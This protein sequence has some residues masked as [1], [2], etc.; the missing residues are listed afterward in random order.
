MSLC[1]RRTRQVRRPRCS[2]WAPT[3]SRCIH[4]VALNIHTVALDIH[5]VALDIHTV[6]LD[7][8]TV[9]LN[10]HTVALNI[11]TVALDIHTVALDIHTVALNIHTVALNIQNFALFIH[12]IALNIQ[13]Q[14]FEP[15]VACT[16]AS[17]LA[18][19]CD[20]GA[21]A[22]DHEDGN[23][24]SEVQACSGQ[25]REYFFRTVRLPLARDPRP[26]TRD[27]KL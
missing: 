12:T 26:E 23:L 4:N 20:R 22:S 15:Y 16:S 8:H 2:C 24:D 17:P 7:I 25:D 13:V 19:M 3:S 27:P 10:I 18:A 9:A 5:T 14:Q 21:T 11:H 6:A 1:R